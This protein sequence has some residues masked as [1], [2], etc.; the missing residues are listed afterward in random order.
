MKKFCL[1]LMI[2]VLISTGAA[3]AAGAQEA[4][5]EEIT[6]AVIPMFIG[7]PWFERAEYGARKAAE[8]L[9]INIEYVGPERA[10]AARQLDIFNDQVNRGVDAILLAVS[11]ADMFERP[12]K[13]AIEQGV[14]VFGFDIGAPGELWL[15]SGWEPVASG[16]Q[17]GEGMAEEIGGSGKVAI[18]TGSLGAPYL[19]DRLDATI[20]VLDQ[21]PDIE[22]TGV[23]PTED[24][25]ERALS[26]A[27]SVLHANPDLAGFA[28]MTTT[29]V[30]ASARAVVEA[31]LGGEVAIHGVAMA[32]QNAD[33][34][35]DG[36]VRGGIVLAPCKMTYLGVMIAYNYVTE[37]GRLPE[38]DE[39]FGW[40][41]VP[42]TIPEEQA[43]YAPD[44]LLTPENVDDYEF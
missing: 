37:G 7:H 13:N 10:D 22:V 42:V 33:Y 11:E 15:A 6:I 39:E 36:I 34:V 17:I 43:S 9:G 38:P 35:K 14:P 30:P 5:D 32:Q 8:D 21:Y 40:A 29:G 23:Y 28:C 24:D 18:L 44:V 27:E 26:A 16:T 1:M 2:L 25:Y 20:D 12:V 31:G 3:F 41:G 19:A 4:V